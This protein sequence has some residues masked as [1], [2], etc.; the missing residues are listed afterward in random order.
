VTSLDAERERV[1]QI[2]A[3]PDAQ[4]RVMDMLARAWHQGWLES[5]RYMS[6]DPEVSGQ[7]PFR[8]VRTNA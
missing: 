6:G 5:Q 4:E 7:N 1:L 3:L 8:S 2:L